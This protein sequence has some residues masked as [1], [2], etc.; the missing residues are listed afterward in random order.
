M[1]STHAP[2]AGSDSRPSPATSP[3]RT[4][5]P[6]PPAR[7]ATRRAGNRTLSRS[8]QPTPPARGAT[9][10]GVAGVVARL[11]FQ[12]TPPARGATSATWTASCRSGVSTHAPRAGS[13]VRRGGSDPP[14]DRFNPRPRA[15]SDSR[16]AAALHR[17]GGR[18][19]THAPRAG[20]DLLRRTWRAI[21]WVS[22]H[23]PRAGS[24]SPSP[25]KTRSRAGFNPRP[26][27][28]ERRGR[29]PTIGR[30]TTFQPTPPARGA[31]C[32]LRGPD[33]RDEVS[34]HA[35]RAG[36]DS[37]DESPGAAA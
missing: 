7:G 32:D 6:T 26:P 29:I 11:K 36:S 16:R 25:A 35:P 2:R 33:R 18:V 19:S 27:R 8:F 23:A 21:A 13:D 30:A 15:G 10:D 14:A 31:T 12:P 4:F 3:R 24:D 5:Q 22:T 9:R 34:T 28:G 17:R 1:V 20:S 37:V